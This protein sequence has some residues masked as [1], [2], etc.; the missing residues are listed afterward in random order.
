MTALT[1]LSLGNNKQLKIKY[2][3]HTLTVLS[4]D[5]QQLADFDF[6]GLPNI[7]RLHTGIGNR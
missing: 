4:A 7:E 2:L 5:Y 1:T 3:P 6:N